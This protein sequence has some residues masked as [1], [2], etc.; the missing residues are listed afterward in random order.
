MICENVV[1]VNQRAQCERGDSSCQ[2]CY[3]Y[4]G[5]NFG[6]YSVYYQTITL[7][8]DSMYNFTRPKP[9]T[10]Y[11]YGAQAPLVQNLQ[12]RKQFSRQDYCPS[13]SSQL[14][15]TTQPQNQ[16]PIKPITESG[17]ECYPLAPPQEYQEIYAKKNP[18]KTQPS[19]NPEKTLR[20]YS[21]LEPDFFLNSHNLGGLWVYAQKYQDPCICE[22]VPASCIPAG[23]N[24]SNYRNSYSADMCYSSLSTATMNT[25][26]C[27][28]IEG[29]YK[30]DECIAIIAQWSG[31]Q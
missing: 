17:A 14:S 23:K 24:I 27:D 8:C 28:Y 11:T 20:T 26:S 18:Q 29:L 9:I 22:I 13:I 10:G 4:K 7:M 1:G 3:D 2:F 21:N 6:T 19:C 31:E 15:Q 25:T 5:T 16:E 30:R 12:P